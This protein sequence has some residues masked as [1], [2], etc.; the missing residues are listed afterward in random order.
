MPIITATGNLIRSHF[1][2][3]PVI[4][5][6][7]TNLI[8]ILN[9]W[10]SPVVLCFKPVPFREVLIII[11]TLIIEKILFNFNHRSKFCITFAF[12]V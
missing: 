1:I 9:I 11:V 2:D 10:L 3:L 8:Y 5:L 4:V 6:F 12:L 7:L